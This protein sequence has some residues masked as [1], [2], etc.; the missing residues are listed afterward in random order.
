M[1][2][3]KA[4][5]SEVTFRDRNWSSARGDEDT[6]E[7]DAEVAYGRQHVPDDRVRALHEQMSNMAS[8][9]LDVVVKLKQLKEVGRG[10]HIIDCE[11][12]EQQHI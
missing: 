10:Y 12:R 3:P 5:D 7:S 6:P 1:S 8:F 4:V 11:Q 2:S 9:L